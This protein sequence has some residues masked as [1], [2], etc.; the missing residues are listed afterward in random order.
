MSVRRYSIP[1]RFVGIKRGTSELIADPFT[2]T[3]V[4]PS[5]VTEGYKLVVDAEI[6]IG[7]LE[8][9]ENLAQET[10]LQETNEIL[11]DIESATLEGKRIIEVLSDTDLVMG[12]LTLSQIPKYFRI[13]NTG[14]EDLVFAING[15][16]VPVPFGFALESGIDTTNGSAS[17]NVTGSSTFYFQRMI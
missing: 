5:D 10:T 13:L 12:V 7:T 9:G 1:K 6:S 8:L 15:I 4:N 16:Q 11:N 2:F 17:V 14:D 3:P